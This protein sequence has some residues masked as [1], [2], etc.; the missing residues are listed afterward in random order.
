[1]YI[2]ASFILSVEY[3]H[4]RI[5]SY[6][7]K[8]IHTYIGRNDHGQLGTGD[9][10]TYPTPVVLPSSGLFPNGS[11]I[12]KVAT[13]RS[14]SLILLDSGEVYGC[15]SN[16]QGQLGLGDTKTALKDTLRFVKI[17][18]LVNIRDISCGYDHSICCDRSGRVFTFGHPQFGQLG[19][20][21]YMYIYIYVYV[22]IYIFTYIYIYIY[23]PYV[24]NINYNII[25]I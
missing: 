3:I 19:V 15:G 11:I 18:S 17:T 1:M 9:I 7:N 24:L 16:T 25:D 13:G 4:I 21:I 5:Y 2:Y 12:V 8:H 23:T 20:C 6:I 14:H 22:H 10:I